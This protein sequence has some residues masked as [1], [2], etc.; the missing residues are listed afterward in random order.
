M[1]KNYVQSSPRWGLW[2]LALVMWLGW[3]PARAQTPAQVGNEWIVPGQTYYKVKILKDGLY[4]LDYQYLTQAGITGVAPN[5]LQIWRRGREIAT[6]VGGNQTSL[7]PTSFIEFYAV[8]NDGKLDVELYKRPQDQP[9]QYYNYYTDTASYFITWKAG[10]QGRHMAQPTAAGGAVHPHRIHNQLNLRIGFYIEL[11]KSVDVYLPWVEPAEGYFNGGGIRL[12]NDSLIRSI[13]STG[14]APRLEVQL[15]GATNSTSPSAHAVQVQVGP[16][17]RMRSLGVM[18]WSGR[19][20][21]RQTFTL[22]RSDFVNDTVRVTTWKDASALPGDD[23]YSSYVRF[24]VPQNN[25]W[26]KNRHSVMFQNDSTLAGPATYEYE[27]DSIPATVAGYDVQDLYNVQRVVSTASGTRRRFVFPDANAAATHTLLLTDEATTPRPP[28]PARRVTFRTINPALANFIIITHPQ[29]M[30]PAAGATNAALEYAKYRANPGAGLQ[31]YDTLMVTTFQL[32][33]QFGYGD[34][35]WLAMRHFA[36]WMAAASPAGSQRYLLLLGKGIEPANGGGFFLTDIRVAPRTLGERGIDLVPTSTRSVS[37]NLLTA[38]FANNDFAAK[39]NT[40][41]L[42]VTTPAQVM[43]YLSKLREYERAGDQPWRKNV[44]HLTGGLRANEFVPFRTYVDKYKQH[45]ESPLFGG[46]VVKTFERLIVNPTS[47]PSLL[48]DADISQE[49]NAGLGVI[50]YFGHGSNTSFALDIGTPTKNPT[51][52]NAGKYPVMMYDGCFAGNLYVNSPTFFEDWLFS[53]NKGAIGCMGTTGFGFDGYLDISKDLYTKLLYNDPTWFGKPFTAVYNETVRQLQRAP[54]GVFN[55]ASNPD[56]IATEQLLGTVWHGDPTIT[57]YAPALPDFQVSNATLG[58]R[59]VAP[60]LT[61]TANSSTFSLLIGVSNPRRVTTD[62]VRIRVTRTVGSNAPLVYTKAFAQG[63]QGNATYD[64]RLPS[65]AGVNVF[66]VNAFKVEIDYNN[67][68]AESDET[69]N[70]AFINYTFLRGG[71]T[72]L[73]PVEFA[74]VGNSTPRLVAQTNDPLGTSRVYE[75]EADTSAAFG[76]SLKRASGPVTATLTPSWRPTLPSVAGRDSVVWYWRVRFQAPTADEDPNWAVSSFRIIQG[77]AAGGWSQSHF[78]QFRRDQRTGVEVSPSGHWAFSTENAPL[79]FRT[80]GGGLPGAAATFPSTSGLGIIANALAPPALNLCGRNTPNLLVAVY[81]ERTLR[82]I[83]GLPAPAVCG[84]APQQFYIFGSDPAPGNAGD[85]LNT[86]NNSAARQAQLSAFLAAVPDG[87]YVAVVSMNRLRWASIG[88]VRAALSTLL[89]SQLVSQLQNGDPFTLLAQK[90]AGGGR[91]IREQGPSTAT[92]AGPRYSQIISFSDTLR[93]PTTRGTITSVRIGPAKS[94]ENLYHWIQREPNATS[95]YTLKVIGID[96]LGNSQVLVASVPAGSPSRGGYSLSTISARQYPNLQLEL[97]MQDTARRQ[98]PQLKEWFI[99]YQG[100]PE[101][102]VRRDLAQ[103]ANIY[104]PATLTAQVLGTGTLSIPVVFENVTPFSFG[105]PLRAKVELTQGNVTRPPVYVTLP[106]QVKGDSVVTYLAKVPMLGV[107]GCY[108]TKVTV[109]PTPNAQPEQNLFNNELNLAQFCVADPNLPP[110]LDV[111]VDGR[112]ILNGELVSARPVITI[113][114]KDEDK[115][116]HITSASA[117]TVTLQ[118]PGQAGA[119]TPVNLSGSNVRFTVDTSN[120]SLATLTYEP[121]QSAPLADGMYT[122]K[123]QGRDPSNSAA[124]TQEF[125]VKFEVVSTSQISNV[126]PYPNPVVSKA[127]FVFT[128]TGQQLPT[129]M[130]IQIMSLT[131]R[132]VREIFMSE[133]GPLHIGNN[134]SEYAWDGTDTY[135]DRLA[136]GTYLYRVALDDPNGDFKHRATA[137]D[138]AFKNDW[139]KLVLMR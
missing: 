27:N 6:Y 68:V 34:R 134:I 46:R 31:R 48:V 84:Q 14:P 108:T 74:I 35:S 32:Y 43:V 96:T 133:L 135:G 11:P 2:V 7:D 66:G 93:T 79:L 73:H 117:F 1:C 21:Y 91:L 101:G 139:G 44:L 131:G 128:L 114:L 29:L 72:T 50:Q 63:L 69:N 107:F 55:P 10:V 49:L 112:H 119:G 59:P 126:Y 64:F 16:S 105:T 76:S 60:D 116:R 41:R 82:P 95:S 36:R 9:H 99:T 87:A 23:F 90:R 75:F 61:V 4:K 110:V 3:A 25:R 103:P 77:R 12:L 15:Y 111:A 78:A 47:G 52:N 104:D 39:L 124:G 120:G 57:L 100:V 18:R 94:W 137:G 125:Q 42:T 81:D 136:N 122:L 102:V 19:V 53:A 130:K 13:A 62:S 45:V 67:V 89:G 106:R 109:N 5:Q 58:I 56:D 132:V 28:L 98:A 88:P 17:N 26:F 80:V 121:G 85:T 37:D 123:V 54:N 40:G 38:D 65:P 20:P 113:Q 30:K 51:Y 24:I 127:R 33:D 118:G 71:V 86:L 138:Q 129:N 115:L 92:A 8:H 97:T 22:Q 70:I 83:T